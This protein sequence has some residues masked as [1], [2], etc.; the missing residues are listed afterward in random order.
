MFEPERLHDPGTQQ[1]APLAAQIIL[2]E[3]SDL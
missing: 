2:R 1:T 3:D